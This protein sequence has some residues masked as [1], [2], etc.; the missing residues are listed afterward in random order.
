[1]I[2]FFYLFYCSRELS[3][4]KVNLKSRIYNYE[5]EIRCINEF[6]NVIQINMKHNKD[7]KNQNPL[8][9]I[10]R[11]KNEIQVIN[12]KINALKNEIQEVN[13]EMEKYNRKY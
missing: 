10:V 2:F 1:M 3:D 7:Y 13:K 12:Q 6:I 5:N 11:K 4:K 8:S 9:L